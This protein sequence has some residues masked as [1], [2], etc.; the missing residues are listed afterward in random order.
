LRVRKEKPRGM[1]EK[2]G[3]WKKEMISPVHFPWAPRSQR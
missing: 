3:E 1:G 2:G